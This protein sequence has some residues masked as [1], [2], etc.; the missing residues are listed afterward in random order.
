[1]ETALLE[2]IHSLSNPVW[3]RFFKLSDFF[4]RSFFI[5]PA[6]LEKRNSSLGSIITQWMV[7][8]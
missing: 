3:D 5:V 2:W 4:G 6:V 8:N 1:M 7:I